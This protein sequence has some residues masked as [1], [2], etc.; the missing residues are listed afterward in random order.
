MTLWVSPC[1]LTSSM[2]VKEA[3]LDRASTVAPNERRRGFFTGCV[4]TL[5]GEGR[6][7]E[8]GGDKKSGRQAPPVLW[9]SGLAFFASPRAPSAACGQ[10]TPLFFIA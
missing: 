10:F 9:Q 1:T 2:H 7:E 6:K 4:A 5:L 8:E 3:L